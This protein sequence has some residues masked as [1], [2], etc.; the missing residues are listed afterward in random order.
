[1]AT[2]LCCEFRP[3]HLFA[4]AMG[5]AGFVAVLAGLDDDR[6][7]TAADHGV[8]LL[9]TTFGLAG[10]AV[11]LVGLVVDRFVIVICVSSAG[12]V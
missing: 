6:N 9:R 1:M 12:M 7:R 10:C 2:V 3:L 4:M 5:P 8:G 11:R